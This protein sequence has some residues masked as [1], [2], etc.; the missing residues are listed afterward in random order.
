MVVN[1]LQ[2]TPKLEDFPAL[3]GLAAADK[4]ASGAADSSSSQLPSTQSSA[5]GPAAVGAAA[6]T[7]V[8]DALK[9]ANKA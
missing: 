1:T 3:G 2:A 7:G 8:S 6:A 9:A 4:P 5:A